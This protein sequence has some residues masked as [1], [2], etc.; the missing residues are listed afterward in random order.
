MDAE[1]TALSD[2]GIWELTPL[3]PGKSVVGCRWIYTVKFLLDGSVERLKAHFVA[4]G[5]TQIYGLDF[6]ETFS[7]V[8]KLASVRL[9]LAFAA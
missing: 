2:S 5:Y 6:S 9:F 8:A 7:P 3:P 1:I 4:K